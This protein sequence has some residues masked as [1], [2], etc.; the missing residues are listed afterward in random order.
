MAQIDTLK[1]LLGNP[2]V[3]DPELQFYLDIAGDII[4]DIRNTDIVESKYSN[5][6]IQMAIELFNKRG[7]EGQTGHSENGISRTYDASDISNTLIA[8][9]TPFAKTPFSTERTVI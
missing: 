6:Q 8:K 3:T 4:C 1:L 2:S 7:A 5:V 9:V